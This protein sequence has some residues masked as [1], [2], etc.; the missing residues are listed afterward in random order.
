MRYVLAAAIAAAV[1]AP[2][3]AVVSYSVNNAVFASLG[4]SLGTE[5]DKLTII[6]ASGVATTPG[7]Y[8][9]ADYT[10][11]VGLNSN[12]GG[13]FTGVFTFSGTA[14]AVTT[15]FSTPYDITISNSDTLNFGG[16]PFVFGP[17]KGTIDAVQIVN[18]G[19]FQSTGSI[20]A[21]ITSVPEPSEW[22]LLV[23]G[24]GLVGFAA[25]RRS[26]AVAA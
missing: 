16:T 4:D 15:S 5:I 18:D 2:A 7:T 6:G 23:I 21:T 24:F 12:T 3:N 17:F 25:R 20:F 19:S 13:F 10:F 1:V 8:K 26:V 14:G 9:L 22:A 11:D